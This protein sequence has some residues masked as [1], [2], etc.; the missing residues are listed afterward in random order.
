MIIILQT[1]FAVDSSLSLL[2]HSKIG[3]GIAYYL[4]FRNQVDFHFQRISLYVTFVFIRCICMKYLDS[5]WGEKEQMVDTCLRKNLRNFQ[6]SFVLCK[7]KSNFVLKFFVNMYTLSCIS[8][9]QKFCLPFSVFLQKELLIKCF[10]IKLQNNSSAETNDLK[11]AKE[12]QSS[13]KK[14]GLRLL[15]FSLT[16]FCPHGS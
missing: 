7:L 5:L 14:F 9:Q 12:I 13:S 1:E 8:C 3:I 6:V 10:E 15:R 16:Y 11:Q 2:S 4:R